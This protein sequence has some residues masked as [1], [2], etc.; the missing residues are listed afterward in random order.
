MTVQ[1]SVAA[2]TPI[3]KQKYW[4]VLRGGFDINY[5]DWG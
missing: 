1:G 5:R 2:A 3:E 4:V